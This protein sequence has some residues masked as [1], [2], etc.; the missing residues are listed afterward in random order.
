MELAGVSQET[1]RAALRVPRSVR[2]EAASTGRTSLDLATVA[3][4]MD[5]LGIDGRG[6]GPVQRKYLEILDARGPRR[7]LGLGRLAVILG[8]PQRTLERVHEPYLFRLG[9]IGTTPRGRV[10]YCE[11]AIC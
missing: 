10:A 3:R 8:V 9:L 5:R 1:P 4:A 6:L 11:Q 2:S 7:P